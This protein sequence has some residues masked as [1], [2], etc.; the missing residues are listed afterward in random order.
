MWLKDGYRSSR[1]NRT[2]GGSERYRVDGSIQQQLSAGKQGSASQTDLSWALSSTA[3]DEQEQVKRIGG[4]LDVMAAA[5]I[6]E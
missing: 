6:Q 3:Q 5:R 1:E 2:V 4:K